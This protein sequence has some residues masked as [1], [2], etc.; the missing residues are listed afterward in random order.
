MVDKIKSEE[1]AEE[2]WSALGYKSSSRFIYSEEEMAEKLEREGEKPPP[3]EHQEKMREL[4]IREADNNQR[5][6]REIQRLELDKELG[7]RSAESVERLKQEEI[8]AR[9]LTDQSKIQ[10][11][12]DVAASKEM[13]HIYDINTRRAGG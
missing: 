1:I 9:R 5:H 12:R 4:D 3:L 8:N 13:S 11:T 10:A 7:F 6:E 2:I